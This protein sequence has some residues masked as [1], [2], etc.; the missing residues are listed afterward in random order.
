MNGDGV[1]YV[2]LST[3]LRERI[4]RDNGGGEERA[5]ENEKQREEKDN[6]PRTFQSLDRKLEEA[7]K[8]DPEHV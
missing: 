1:L 5:K 4:A 3:R 8:K 6:G 7:K 2:L